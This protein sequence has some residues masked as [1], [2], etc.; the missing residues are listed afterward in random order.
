MTRSEARAFVRELARRGITGTVEPCPGGGWRVRVA[1][2][3]LG[4]EAV[5]VDAGECRWFLRDV[6]S[7]KARRAQDRRMGRELAA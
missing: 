4:W 1:P 5:L 2:W 7:C 3:F 6:R